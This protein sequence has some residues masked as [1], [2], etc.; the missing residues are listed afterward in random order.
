MRQPRYAHAGTQILAVSLL[1]L[2]AAVVG[3]QDAAAQFNQKPMA[4][5]DLSNIYTETGGQQEFWKSEGTGMEWPGIWQRGFLRADALWIGLKNFEDENGNSF[6][7]KVVHV[8]PRST[9]FGEYFPQEFETVARFQPPE[10]TVDGRRTLD[11]TL[12]VDRVDP[13]LPS[14]RMIRMR[15]NTQTGIE[16]EKRIYAWSQDYHDNYHIQEYILTNTGN[17]DNDQEIELPDQTAE[18]VY[19]H[20]QR[21]Y[22][23]QDKSSIPGSGW[24]A[25]MMSD[26]V[27]DG[28]QDYEVDF[29]ASYSWLGNS[30][31]AEI[32]PLG[33]PAWDDSP[34]FIPDGDDG[35]QLTQ[36]AHIG[37]ATLHADT[38]PSDP[39]ND[40]DQPSMTG[41][42]NSDDPI[43]TG[44]DA[45]N[46][47][48]MR[49]EYQYLSKA[50]GT[51]LSS[52][53][54]AEANDGH[55]FPHQADI[56]DEDGNFKTADGDAMLGT[57]GGW[58]LAWSYGPYTLEPGESVRIVVA[59]GVAG[60]DRTTSTLIGRKWKESANGQR[61]Q[62]DPTTPLEYDSDGDG[63]IQ[64]DE[65][66]GKNEW[67]MST[68]DS[69]FQTFER[70]I[71]HFD[72]GALESAGAIPNPPKPPQTFDVTAGVD[73]IELE[74]TT[75]DDTPQTEEFEVYRGRERLMGSFEREKPYTYEKI[76][77]VDA[78]G[79][80]EYSIVDEDAIRGVNYF[81]YVRAVGPENTDGSV[82]T[83]T[84]T[85]LRSSRYYS[86]T[87]DPAT[88]KRP[89]G[90]TTDAFRVVPNPFNIS[91]DPSVRWP[92]RDNRIGFLEIPGNSIIRIYTEMGEL[93]NTIRH[94]DG[95]G[96]EF[97]DLTTRDGQLVASGVYIA[98]VQNLD[99]GEVSRKKFVI[100]R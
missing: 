9:G 68:R 78:D 14:E 6:E 47:S 97:W 52:A 13:S 31:N 87:Y 69:L 38:S 1:L 29:H 59:E 76:E 16:L 81:Y 94:D 11:N 4:I 44:N 43:N 15:V 19:L 36:A 26:V 48:Q 22:V 64:P 99:N 74:W 25:N 72:A 30:Q 92:S 98:V 18:D 61:S 91:S 32:D 2:G 49:Q 45:F 21:R 23:F 10:V 57:A 7:R 33:A 83:P 53:S 88:L 85:R 35:G 41:F 54:Q 75:Y 56:V 86:Q 82:M 20:M 67:V 37:V 100:V 28:Q 5:G 8:G 66:L 42:V 84:G 3:P 77:T 39:S 12:E 95:S 46:E 55:E 90:E 27:G 24:G 40:P 17:T 65:R 34:A 63:T 51:G 93:V 79:S 89:P 80:G 96:D 50:Q 70:A 71:A 60:L 62:A 73:Q 58:S